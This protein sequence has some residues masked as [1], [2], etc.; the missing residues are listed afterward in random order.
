M[1]TDMSLRDLLAGVVEPVA[2]DIVVSGL[3]LDSRRVRP[4]DAFVALKGGTTHGMD[5]MPMAIE[6]GAVAILAESPDAARVP[7]PASRVPVLQIDN[8]RQHL[9]TIAARFFGDPSSSLTLLGVT[10]T[11]GKTSTVQ[12]LSHALH[13]LGHASASIGTLG[14]GFDGALEAG[15]RTTPDVISVHAQLAALRDAGASHVAMEVSSHALDQHRVDGVQFK[16]AVFTNLTRDHLDY[17]GTMQAY[18]EAKARLFAWPTLEA[19]VINIDDAFGR[20]LAARIGDRVACLRTSVDGQAD[21]GVRATH[22]HALAS[23]LDFHLHTPWG[24]GDVQ[25][26]LLGRFNVANLLAVAACLGALGESFERIVEVLGRLQ[27]VNGRMSRLGGHDGA[28]LLVVDYSH[29]P[30]ALEQALASL[31]AHCAGR[32]ICVFGCGGDRDAGKRPEMGAIAERLADC[33]I[34]T[35]DNPRSED[36]DAIVADILAGLSRRDAARV[37]RDRAQ[38]IAQA[39]DM[40]RPEDVILVAGKGHETYQEVAGERRPFDDMAVARAAMEARPC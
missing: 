11:N 25:S 39:L 37:R 40:A 29:T 8:L 15:E 5:F 26:P 12:M 3:T 21:A 9:G 7:S 30:D 10:G 35:D 27:P 1:T 22:V 17:H 24:E 36:G 28:P 32:L 38:A 20:E 4:G 14:V 33:I 23:G 34:V 6:R 13:L 16:L 19:A 2:D 18:G 31:R